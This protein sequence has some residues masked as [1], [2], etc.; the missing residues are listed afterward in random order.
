MKEDVSAVWQL[1]DGTLQVSWEERV[2]VRNVLCVVHTAGNTAET[3]LGL[4]YVANG[5]PRLALLRAADPEMGDGFISR[6]VDT[7]RWYNPTMQDIRLAFSLTSLD[8][9]AHHCADDDARRVTCSTPEHDFASAVQKHS[10]GVWFAGE[11]EVLWSDVV[12]MEAGEQDVVLILTPRVLLFLGERELLLCLHVKDIE[13]VLWDP[14]KVCL[15]LNVTTQPGPLVASCS[16]AE[17]RHCL[18][19][20]LFAL[21]WALAHKPLPSMTGEC[22]QISQ[23]FGQLALT[24][25]M[26]TWGA[27]G[28]HNGHSTTVWSR[29]QNSDDVIGP[30]GVLSPEKA[31]RAKQPEGPHLSAVLIH[32]T[33]LVLKSNDLVEAVPEPTRAHL[34]GLEAGDD[35]VAHLRAEVSRK[36]REIETAKSRLHDQQQELQ[37]RKQNTRELEAECRKWSRAAG[38]AVQLMEF[39]NSV[40]VK[41]FL[42]QEDVARASVAASERAQYSWLS[43]C[44]TKSATIATLRERQATIDALVS[45]ANSVERTTSPGILQPAAAAAQYTFHATHSPFAGHSPAV[46]PLIMQKS[47]V[48]ERRHVSEDHRGNVQ[49]SLAPT[50]IVKDLMCPADE[51]FGSPAPAGY[52]HQARMSPLAKDSV[53]EGKAAGTQRGASGTPSPSPSPPSCERSDSTPPSSTT[54][55]KAIDGEVCVLITNKG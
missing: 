3:A 42:K 32:D 8:A 41:Q 30:A 6:V 28:T 22:H 48:S 13:A 43:A 16:S 27:E 20:K 21:Y 24:E 15:L 29:G 25:D 53:A 39:S 7:L 4:R 5:L 37:H 14:N 17:A 36:K 10:E 34:Q 55:M 23:D 26:G 45:E 2:E 1:Q 35:L 33:D 52:V 19:G 50:G 44:R 46:S 31:R 12:R 54:A 47:P 38:E 11:A 49:T 9:L 51:V 40:M 18:H